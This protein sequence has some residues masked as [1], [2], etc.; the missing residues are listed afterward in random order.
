MDGRIDGRWAVD[1]KVDGVWNMEL[2]ESMR[3]WK[4]DGMGG[5][6]NMKL[7]GR[8]NTDRMDGWVEGAVDGKWMGGGKRPTILNF[9]WQL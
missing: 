5:V 4:M 1:E 9:A 3:R 2:I 8:W 6:W 7:M